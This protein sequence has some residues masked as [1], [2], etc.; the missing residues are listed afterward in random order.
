MDGMGSCG[1]AFRPGYLLFL[2][3]WSQ[4]CFADCGAEIKVADI[5]FGD[6]ALRIAQNGTNQGPLVLMIHG[7]PDRWMNS[8]VFL[9]N[10]QLTSRALVVS[11]DRLGWG[12][13]PSG[14]D[15][16]IDLRA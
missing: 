8:E 10:E 5:P 1:S 15:V 11:M 7:T 3:W 14:G 13:A 4:P 16:G 2:I 9:N 12:G 6:G